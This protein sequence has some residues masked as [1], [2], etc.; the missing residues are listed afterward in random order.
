MKI[1]IFVKCNNDRWL[2]RPDGCIIYYSS[3]RSM[4]TCLKDCEFVGGY[5][6]RKRFLERM[7]KRYEN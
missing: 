2:L 3:W 6:F 7:I 4:K 5:I 1:V